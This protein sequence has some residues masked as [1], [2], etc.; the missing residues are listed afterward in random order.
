[1][2]D[3]LQSKII[4]EDMERIF[5]KGDYSPLRGKTVLISGAYGMLASYMVYFLLYLNKIHGYKINIIS[6]SRSDKKLK[7]RFG[8]HTSDITRLTQSV[9]EPACA[10]CDYIIHAAGFA[11]PQ[12]YTVVPVDVMLPNLIGTHNLLELAH[13]NNA[14]LLYFST[15]GVYGKYGENKLRTE[16]DFGVIDTLNPHSCY[17]ESKRAGETLCAAYCKQKGVQAVIARIAHTYGPTAD[18]END[19]RVFASF[20]KNAVSKQDIVIKSD[21]LSKRSFCYITD[22]AAAYLRLTLEG[23]AGEA[24]NVCNEEQTVSINELGGIISKLAGVG[25]TYRKRPE[26]DTYLQDKNSG[27]SVFSSEKLRSLGFAFDVN[28]EEGF[29]RVLKYFAE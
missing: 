22:A 19:P 24:Y 13:R 5:A 27:T 15:C 12:Y 21:G 11:S 2:V 10:Y 6:L 4:Y 29:S 25:F 14:R 3:F 16:N 9:C 23:K 26:T 8:A 18:I 17:D 28:I 7:E 20:V 1:M